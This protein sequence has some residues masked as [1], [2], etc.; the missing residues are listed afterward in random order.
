MALT[1]THVEALRFIKFIRVTDTGCWEWTGSLTGRNH[2]GDRGG[3]P[4]FYLR[5]RQTLA[6]RV[7][8]AAVTGREADT[9]EHTCRNRAC[10]RFRCFED[11]PIRENILRGEGPAAQN[12]RKIVCKRGHPLDGKQKNGRL[13]RICRR[14]DWKRYRER[15][16]VAAS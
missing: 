10:V 15:K 11:L 14:A 8:F 13:C 9:V 1:L 6:H 2:R 4:K 12:A 3:Y 16:A 7:M 5:G